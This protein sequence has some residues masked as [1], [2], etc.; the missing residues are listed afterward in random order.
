MSKRPEELPSP[1]AITPETPLRLAVAAAIAFPDG[2][3]TVSGLR[4]EAKRG[5]LA[6][7][8][9]AGKDYT[10]LAAIGRMREL[11]R[12][13]FPDTSSS[14]DKQKAPTA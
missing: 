6:I 5:R 2:S 13:S 11:C 14:A 8:R 3:M 10:T 4:K 12:I 1:N 7:E 9:V